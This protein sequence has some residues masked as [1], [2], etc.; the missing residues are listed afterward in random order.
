MSG[1]AEIL[2]VGA[3]PVGLALA[4]AL[5]RAGRDVRMVDAREAGAGSLDARVLAL[6]HGS[7]QTLERLAA[8]P[9]SGWTAIEHIHVSQRGALGRTRIEACDYGV[10]ALGYVVPAAK[11]YDTLLER[12]HAAGIAIDHATRVVRFHADTA[13]LVAELE[14]ACS[15]RIEARLAACCEGGVGADAAAMKQHDYSQHA[16]IAR[17][18]IAQPHGNLAYERFTPEGPLAL[19]PHGADYS[20]VWTVS[21]ERAGQLQAS[22]DSRFCAALQSAFGSRVRFTGV[23]ERAAFPLGLKV[24]AEPVGQRRIWLGNAAQT[25]HPVA[26]QGFNL[27]LRDVWTLVGLL[28]AAALADPGAATLLARYA[29]RR[30]LDRAGTI[31]FTDGMVRLFSNT[32]PLLQHLR[33]AGLFA[34][35][36]LPPLRHF[37]AKRMLF[38]ARAWP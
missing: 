12:V 1:D 9:A 30:R 34:L 33:G 24:R 29:Q 32:D 5:A 17:A 27:A 18:R 15:G 2:V 3:G 10:P 25:M 28:D 31:G 38:G 7:R 6:S 23:S 37:L 35:D 13:S 36:T 4:L 14:G 11:L 22:D 19:L 8:W 20:V 26:G 16:L 21:P